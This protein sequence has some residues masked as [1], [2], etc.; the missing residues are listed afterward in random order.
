M[1]GVFIFLL[2][3]VQV[4]L[5]SI[6][7]QRHFTMEEA[8]LRKGGALS[9]E[10]LYNFRWRPGTSD[11]SHV[12]GDTLF[13]VS[14]AKSGEQSYVLLS[15]LQ[16][17]LERNGMRSVRYWPSYRW[18]GQQELELWTSE[19]Q[20]F[21]S[22]DGQSLRKGW[23]IPD[24]ADNVH[25]APRSTALSYNIRQRVEIIDAQGEHHIVTADTADGIVNGRSVHQNEFGISGGIFWSPKGGR[26]AFYRMDE[27]MV[28][29]YPLV[30]ISTREASATPFRYPMAG[31]TSHEVRVG[32][33]TIDSKQLVWLQT[34]PPADHYLTNVSWDPDERY[35]YL[36]EIN[37]GQ[38]TMRLNRYDAATGAFLGELFTETDSCYVE[39]LNGLLFLPGHNDRFIWQS[40]RSG[41]NHVYLYDTSGKLIRP[42]TTGDWEVLDVLGFDVSG[43]TLYILSNEFGVIDRDLVSVDL[44]SGKRKRLTQ[45]SG[46]HSIYLD[47]EGDRFAAFWSSFDNPGG[48]YWGDLSGR[49][50][51]DLLVSSDPLAEYNLPDRRLVSLK[52]ADG[53]T[54]LYGRLFVPSDRKGGSRFPVV[55]YVYGGPHAQMVKN[56][57]MGGAP[58]WELLMAQRGYV[59]FVVD[60]R[61]SANRGYDFEQVTHRQLG[62]V[63]LADQQAG[64]RY[65]KAQPFVDSTRMGVHGWSYGGFMTM[66]MLLR[67]GT[68][69]QVGVAGGP[70]VDWQYYEI[71]YGE[72]YMD[73]PEENPE[74]YRRANLR[75]YVKDLEGKR[76]LILHGYQDNVVVP[77]H[78]LSFLKA[79]VDA[80][81]FEV[82]FFFY[83]GHPHNVRGRDR[84]HLMNK[85]TDYFDVYLRGSER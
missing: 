18:S 12:R 8:V 14:T 44:A 57:W 64:I 79:A 25:N 78:S 73:T 41:H 67:S 80:G 72:R 13:I 40:Q 54:D 24:G 77:Q 66:H 38:D 47:P 31:R 10:S 6:C 33:Y 27:S 7:A 2:L 30:D 35:V 71:M 74:G 62:E 50:T 1:K 29:E 43:K 28:A 70:V 53:K 58:Y 85:V 45:R 61:G 68:D 36:A 9:P 59:V 16:S 65:L 11:Y 34:P 82:D 49:K 17:Q 26:L 48:V 42:V 84:I 69:L 75:E 21:F 5:T 23:M 52:A 20:I 15:A 81:R 32:V 19:G 83:P 46:Y 37:R 51:A 60:N 39:P 63:E 22:I 3:S 56:T 55:I 4:G 76:L